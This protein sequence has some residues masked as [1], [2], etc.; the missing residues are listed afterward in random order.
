MNT[1]KKHLFFLCW[2]FSCSLVPAKWFWGSRGSNIPITLLE[3]QK[4]TQGFVQDV[5][6]FNKSGRRHSALRRIQPSI[7]CR[8]IPFEDRI[9]PPKPGNVLRIAT[10]GDSCTQGCAASGNKLTR[11]FCR[12]FWKKRFPVSKSKSWTPRWGPILPTRDW[13]DLKMLWW[14]YHP[15]SRDGLFRMEWSLGSLQQD[16]GVRV[17]SGGSVAFYNVMEQFR[18]FQFIHYL[19]AKVKEK[20]SGRAAAKQRTFRVPLAGY[21]KKIWTIWLIS[22]RRTRSRS[23]WS[24]PPQNLPD[25]FSAPLL[26]PY[27][28]EIL[29][30]IHE[31]YN[32]IVRKVAAERGVF[33]LDLERD[34]SNEK[35]RATTCRRM[36]SISM[37]Q[38]AAL[39]QKILLKRSW[40]SIFSFADSTNR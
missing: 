8:F 24:R 19:I 15:E 39:W 29:L 9:Q 16:S 6:N 35:R 20:V 2:F 31:A 26:F 22:P 7:G 12:I 28:F 1:I 34:P 30:K 10:L 38:D 13:S 4:F 21:E 17:M 37:P 27:S 14:K 40:K 11:I 3:M 33:L 25:N 5:L 32:D 36:E 18:T 23:C